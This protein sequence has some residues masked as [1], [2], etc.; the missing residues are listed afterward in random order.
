MSRF[1]TELFFTVNELSAIKSVENKIDVQRLMFD[2]DT[3]VR[4]DKDFEAMPS[5]IMANLVG[6]NVNVQSEREQNFLDKR[7]GDMTN[8]TRMQNMNKNAK[9]QNI[10]D[11]M[12]DEGASG[13]F[14]GYGRTGARK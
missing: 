5:L 8:R 7:S 12:R 10:I 6:L 9:Y 1:A 14:G 11:V 2:E 4:N 13:V 3:Y